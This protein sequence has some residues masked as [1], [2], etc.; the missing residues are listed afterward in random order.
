V[1]DHFD[2]DEMFGVKKS[3]DESSEEIVV[4]DEVYTSKQ[5][6]NY[7]YDAYQEMLEKEVGGSYG[8]GGS[9]SGSAGRPRKAASI[10]PLEQGM[11]RSSFVQAR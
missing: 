7:A 5:P 9:G 1:A 8:A 11:M 10:P 6:V 2:P 4:A 3:S